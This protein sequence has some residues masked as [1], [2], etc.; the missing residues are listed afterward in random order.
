[1]RRYIP[2]K[3]DKGSFSLSRLLWA[4]LSLVMI[5]ASTTACLAEQAEQADQ[6]QIIVTMQ[7]SNTVYSSSESSFSEDVKRN[8]RIFQPTSIT[9]SYSENNQHLV[10]ITVG[11]HEYCFKV[12]DMQPVARFNFDRNRRILTPKGLNV[13]ES[14]QSEVKYPSYKGTP[15]TE[16]WPLWR[17]QIE[18]RMEDKNIFIQESSKQLI[19][20]LDIDE[21]GYIRNIGELGGTLRSYSQSCV[22]TIYDIA[23]R[24]WTPA[25]INGQKVRSQAVIILGD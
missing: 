17:E 1:M 18:R 9:H 21:D 13:V 14:S 11:S 10:N 12:S 23:A 2:K 4:V 3:Q 8:L 20:E 5:L 16:L 25:E 19:L 24:E 22:A 7:G 6:L 15:L